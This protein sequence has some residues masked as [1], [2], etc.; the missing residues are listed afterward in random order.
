MTVW[1]ESMIREYGENYA[2]A[3]LDDRPAPV[4]L[5][6]WSLL[7][8][9]QPGAQG[10]DIAGPVDNH[11]LGVSISSDSMDLDTPELSEDTGSGD[12]ESCTAASEFGQCVG[13]MSFL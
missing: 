13:G 8:V 11:D 10:L 9:R 12:S 6:P 2:G 5:Q 7:K 1:S 3:V 4:K